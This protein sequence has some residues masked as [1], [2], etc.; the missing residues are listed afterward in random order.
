MKTRY[1]LSPLEYQ[2]LME[3]ADYKCQICSTRL[4][5]TSD[6][7]ID[8]DHNTGKVRGVLCIRCNTALG[9]FGDSVEGLMK[10]VKYLEQ[11]FI[12]PTPID[13]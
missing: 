9:T 6:K 1:G 7:C 10:A 3:K 11:S 2:Q 8:H 12:S 5:S 13:E 4:S